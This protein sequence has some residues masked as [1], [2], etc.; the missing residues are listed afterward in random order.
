MESRIG[1]SP[2]SNV[3]LLSAKFNQ[4]KKSYHVFYAIRCFFPCSLCTFIKCGAARRKSESDTFKFFS[5]FF[6]AIKKS[7]Y[8]CFFHSTVCFRQDVTFV[9]KKKEGRYQGVC[10]TKTW[11]VKIELNT[12]KPD[13]RCEQRKQNG[14][15]KMSTEKSYF[16]W[17]C[18]LGFSVVWFIHKL[19][20]W[21]P[22]PQ[23]L[24]HK[25]ENYTVW[26]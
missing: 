4:K 10:I 21:K 2:K 8:C 12:Q 3:I 14:G 17:K 24:F 7:E 16:W 15:R 5:F 9:V 13:A 23:N 25:L 6:V 26:W 19:C 18:R 11:N 22:F 1:Y 20:K